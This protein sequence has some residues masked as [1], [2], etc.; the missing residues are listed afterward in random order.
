L[1]ASPIIAFV[2]VFSGK[3]APII[4]V[5]SILYVIF[6]MLTAGIIA[7]VLSL[8]LSILYLAKSK[9]NLYR[10]IYVSSISISFILLCVIFYYW[11]LLGFN[12]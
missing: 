7:G 8:P 11:N 9:T 12:F 5:P 2:W 6:G 3:A 4:G 10:K 1:F